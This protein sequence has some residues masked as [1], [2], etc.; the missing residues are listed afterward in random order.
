MRRLNIYRIATDFSTWLIF[1]SIQEPLVID[2]GASSGGIVQMLD[3][4]LDMTH[5]VILL[6]GVLP[7]WY[8]PASLFCGR[9]IN[10]TAVP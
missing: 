3:L 6:S 4:K 9:I 2:K 10:G 7:M 8:E 5:H 1:D